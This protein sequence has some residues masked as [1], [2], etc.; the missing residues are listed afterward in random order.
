[1]LVGL[2]IEN[3]PYLFG[4]KPKILN[5]GGRYVYDYQKKEEEIGIEFKPNPQYIDGFFNVS[6]DSTVKTTLATAIIGENGVGKSSI[7]KSIF[8]LI[9]DKNKIVNL[10]SLEFKFIALFENNGGISCHGN[11]EKWNLVDENSQITSMTNEIRE[12]QYKLIYYSPH[13]DIINYSF[14]GEDDISV[15][16]KTILDDNFSSDT[17]SISNRSY[18]LLKLTYNNW[19]RYIQFLKSSVFEKETFQNILPDISS[20]YGHLEFNFKKKYYPEHIVVE[21]RTWVEELIHNLDFSIKETKETDYSLLSPERDL[22]NAKKRKKLQFLKAL[23]TSMVYH[24]GIPEITVNN[25][26]PD[27]SVEIGILDESSSL[28]FFLANYLL[29]G[30]SPYSTSKFIDFKNLI[31]KAIDKHYRH[32]VQYIPS[33]S[34][35][36]FGKE[37][38]VPYDEIDI[39]QKTQLDI[40]GELDTLYRKTGYEKPNTKAE[41]LVLYILKRGMSSGEIAF[42]NLF[43]NLFDYVLSERKKRSSYTDYILLIDEGDLGFHPQWKKKYVNLLLESVPYFFEQIRKDLKWQVII[44]THDP[45]TLS[46][47]PNSNVVFIKNN[48]DDNEYFMGIVRNTFGANISELL[49]NSFFIDDGLIGDFAKSKITKVIEWINSVKD[50]N[51]LNGQER[52]R[53]LKELVYQKKVINL[54][55]ERVMRLKL[56]EMISELEESD[57]Y[58]NEQIDRE[59]TRLEKLRKKPKNDLL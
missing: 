10:V 16:K 39:I 14:L 24:L 36:I 43:S 54:I 42:L 44:T 29:R 20:D 17:D 58:Y 31:F 11:I 52:G 51:S 35:T 41:L 34:D 49:S 22:N 7:L 53:F 32:T 9:E 30:S 6:K 25:E 4:G 12:N 28:E 45:F 38:K 23:I 2:Y 13:F 5:F 59:I 37:F 8:N 21:H 18:E 50:N 15:M 55:A 48:R 3:H 56:S 27:S 33:L 19:K 47:F 26:I 46:D 1:M 40:F 57:V